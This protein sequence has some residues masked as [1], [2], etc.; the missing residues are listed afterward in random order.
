MTAAPG[1]PALDAEALLKFFAQHGRDLP[2]RETSAGAWGVLVS[3]VMLQQTPVARVLPVYLAWMRRWPTPAALAADRPGEAVRLWGRLGYPRRALRLHAAA[4]AITRDHGGRVPD[5][6]AALLALPGIGDY[7]ARAVL[8]FAF[9]RR[10]PVVDTNVRR[11]LSRAVRGIDEHGPATKR[12]RADLEELLPAE[13]RRAAAVSA[14]LMELGALR[15]RAV[16][17]ACDDCPLRRGCAWVAAGRPRG[18][19]KRPA[20][21]WHGTDRQMRGAI[22]AVLR[23]HRAPMP[24]PALAA[25]V[26]EPAR[27]N[28]A[29][30]A[31]CL[32]SLV[33]DGLAVRDAERRLALP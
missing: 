17:P 19:A 27:R 3:E 4:G 7:T 26:G 21:R 30:W 14:A 33:A 31:R 23:E 20:Q 8:A 12:D 28:P 32:D 25:A 16:A 22:M 6:L 9:G 11:V 24:V 1:P 10:V 13:P 29:Q 5:D 18:P 2:W 15:C